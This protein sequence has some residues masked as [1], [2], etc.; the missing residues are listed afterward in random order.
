MLNKSLLSNSLIVL[1]I[2][3]VLSSS[4]SY[5]KS[6][7]LLVGVSEYPGLPASNYLEG[8]KNDVNT[9][10]KVLIENWGYSESNI[11]TLIDSQA[12][13]E[14]IIKE[15][16]RLV[17]KVNSNDSVIIYLSGHGTSAKDAGLSFPVPHG[18]GAFIPYDFATKG[19]SAEAKYKTL[20]VGRTDLKPRLLKLDKK[21]KKITYIIDACF[22]GMSARSFGN[23]LQYRNV[24]FG[25]GLE[26]IEDEQASED[27][28]Y[29]YD[30]VV[31]IAAS[32][33]HEKALDI[34]TKLLKRYPT[35]D[36][37]PHGAFT[38]SLLKALT[39]KVAGDKNGDNLMTV[40]EVFNA[41]RT[42]MYRRNY[43]HTPVLFPN[44]ADDVNNNLNRSVFS[45]KWVATASYT[46]NFSFNPENSAK[47]R[48]RLNQ[49][50]IPTS[51][52][53]TALRF[54]MEGHIVDGN[55]D[56]VKEMQTQDFA[57]RL[58]AVQGLHARQVWSSENFRTNN[59]MALSLNNAVSGSTLLEGEIIGIK[60][61]VD[62]DAYFIV[63]GLQSDGEAIVLYPAS[64]YQK[65]VPAE[66]LFTDSNIAKV[67]APFGLD[68]L[69]VYALSD[70]HQALNKYGVLGQFNLLTDKMMA[71]KFKS[72]VNKSKNLAVE[73]IQLYT[74]QKQ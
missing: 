14:G 20:L 63:L 13:K 55:G 27:A 54:S 66:Q 19:S 48:A 10:K 33:E 72:A 65:K 53:A 51:N 60:A 50:N 15:L 3:L 49:L 35:V 22:S 17:E 52:E 71:N 47:L 16:D 58:K 56:V 68:Y 39:G 12:T 29:P 7:A 31:S 74:V 6:Y 5:A 28:V 42:D 32:G 4:Y 36:N 37:K 64:R 34:P 43:S 45:G 40:L 41:V 44:V 73:T 67:Q 26:N 62:F 61:K 23:R 11:K 70:W 69:Q 30:N 57:S 25:I 38:D 24:P 46:D 8:P 18:S 59:S 2:V 21:T 9:F 1:F